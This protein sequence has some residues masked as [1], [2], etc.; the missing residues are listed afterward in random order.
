[1]EPNMDAKLPFGGEKLNHFHPWVDKVA[2]V[3]PKAAQSGLN[4]KNT[5][6]NDSR[7]SKNETTFL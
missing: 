6:Q 5:C 4:L 2:Q 3:V 7:G 1:M